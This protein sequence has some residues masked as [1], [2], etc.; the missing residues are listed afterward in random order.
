MDTSNPPQAVV[1]NSTIIDWAFGEERQ[2][3]GRAER[4]AEGRN[5]STATY[6][7]YLI[8]LRY[9]D[10]TDTTLI[11]YSI[12]LSVNRSIIIA[13]VSNVGTVTRVLSCNL[14]VIFF[15]LSACVLNECSSSQ[16]TI[17]VLIVLMR[18]L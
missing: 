15:G 16:L 14:M 12:D 6:R 8:D 18:I 3:C 7:I 17:F 10:D 4:R 5:G 11:I 2:N 13:F 9:T 1:H